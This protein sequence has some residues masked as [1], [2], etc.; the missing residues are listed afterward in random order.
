MTW[1]FLHVFPRNILRLA[2]LFFMLNVIK[3]FTSEKRSALLL[4]VIPET[5]SD[6]FFFCKEVV[7]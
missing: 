3:E 4:E 6:L 1:K 5:T 2:T 7:Q